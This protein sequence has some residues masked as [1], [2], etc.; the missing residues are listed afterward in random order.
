METNNI[1]VF[2]D[3]LVYGQGDTKE[4]GWVNRLQHKVKGKTKFWNFGIPGDTS[5]D[6]LNRLDKE[7]T[8]KNPNIAFVLIGANDSQYR[9]GGL[10]E[11]TLINLEDY[12]KNLKTISESIKKYT[13]DITFISIP[14]MNDS[15]TKIWDYQYHFCNKN[16]EKYNNEIKKICEENDFIY[17]NIFGLLDEDD[18]SDGAHPNSKGYEKIANKIYQFL[19]DSF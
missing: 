6:L 13:S 9:K 10:E 17:I 15:I 2:G 3:S 7:L 11:E 8:E 5:V 1:S 18:L 16:I 14:N 12:R 4:G 19:V